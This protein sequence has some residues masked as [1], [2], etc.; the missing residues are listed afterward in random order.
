MSAKSRTRR[1]PAISVVAALAAGLISATTGPVSASLVRIASRSAVTV[2]FEPTSDLHNGSAVRVRVSG[3]P[4]GATLLV[5]ECSPKALTAGEDGCENRRNGVFFGAPGTLPATTT[6]QVLASIETALGTVNCAPRGCLIAAVRLTDGNRVSILGVSGLSFSST[7]GAQGGSGPRP[8]PVWANP[9][10]L[11]AGT[12]ITPGRPD[13]LLLAADPAGDLGAPGTV[14]GPSTSLLPGRP[15]PAPEKG[16]A[17]VQL[18]V[19]VPNTSWESSGRTAAVLDVRVGT[20]PAEQIVCFAGSRAFTYAAVFGTVRTG[21]LRVSVALDERLSAAHELSVRLI[22]AKVSVVTA[23]NPAYLEMAYAPVVYGR[24]DSATSDTP[25]LTYVTKTP[26]SAGP[27]GTLQL[28]YTTIWSK[29]D[30]GTSFVPWLEWGEWGRMTDITETIQLDVTPVGRVLHP[31]YDSCGCTSTTP[32]NGTSPKEEEVPFTGRRYGTHLIVRNASGNDYQSETG[33]S[34]FRI[35]QPPV[36]GPSP[37]WDRN[38]VMDAN[39][40]TYRISADELSRW[41][42]DGSTSATS[43]LPGDSRQYAIVELDV[44]AAETSAI[45]VA[46]RLSGS[47]TWYRNDFGSGYS[48]YDG[49]GG[50]TAVKL[51]IGWE[52]ASITA[53]RLLYYPDGSHASVAIS[54]F[55]VLGLTG[56]FAVV[57]IPSPAPSVIRA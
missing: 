10:G 27:P 2:S 1:L 47:S 8:P 22:A 57:G 41:Y 54:R 3:Q 18:V 37:S 46:I 31:E 56:G 5:L 38:A 35:E 24:P 45:A 53:V 28:A 42:S 36:A 51:P 19:E 55:R 32:I 14:T 39:P 16:V 40:W 21:H 13:S 48:L 49:G 25:L 52:R 17:L 11:P 6:F 44:A 43:P 4:K 20:A 34:S 26:S 50:R 9:R 12:I 15:A 29:E 33:T 23:A 7:A 30:A